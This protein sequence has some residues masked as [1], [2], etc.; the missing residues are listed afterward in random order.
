MPVSLAE[1]RHGDKIKVARSTFR[2][3]VCKKYCRLCTAETPDFCILL[4]EHLGNTYFEKIVFLIDRA[5]EINPRLYD[6]LDTFEG[7]VALFC[8][9]NICPFCTGK[10]SMVKRVDCY[11][12]FL[13]QSNMELEP[14]EEGEL[15]TTFDKDIT[16]YVCRELNALDEKQK[17]LSNKKKKRLRK[18]AARI[19]NMMSRWGVKAQKQTETTPAK[20]IHIHKNTVVI[21]KK[22]ISTH[23]FCG[24]SDVFIQR[25]KSIMEGDVQH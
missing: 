1:I 22:E 5:R 12:M 8:D 9:V 10:C 13:T 20:V 16:N 14:G 2:T 11:Q 21:P 18:I 19:I 6:D 24:G 3:E 23:F 17:L 4:L 25:V 15:L 7:F